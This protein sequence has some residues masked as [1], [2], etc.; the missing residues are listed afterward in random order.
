[1]DKVRAVIAAA[2]QGSRMG[3]GLNKQFLLLQG[4]PI[5]AHT[6]RV[7][8]AVGV[9]DEIV[10]ICAAGEKDYY[11]QEFLSNYQITKPLTVVTGGKERQDSVY[12]GLDAIDDENGYVLIHD[13]ARPLV[14]D[15][16]I[17]SVSQEVTVSGAVV[18][19]VPVKDTIKR[20]ND[21]G[22]ITETLQREKLWHIQTPQAFSLDLIRRAHEK[23]RSEGFYGTDDSSL[24]ERMG[25]PVKIIPGSYDNIKITTSEDI[26]IAETILQGREPR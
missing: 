4:M 14:T 17:T 23:A 2:G 25:V 6:L 11:T 26:I 16:I 24:V 22:V 5:I 7:F 21:L 8:Q 3:S 13:G 19:G 1:L 20:T 10:L 9:I 12:C 18:A 15:G